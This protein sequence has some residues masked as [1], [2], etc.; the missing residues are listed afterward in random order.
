[1]NIHAI[2]L[3]EKLNDLQSESSGTKK[4]AVTGRSVD[5]ACNAYC[6]SVM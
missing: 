5:R 6:K 2:G 1:M 4:R 3:F